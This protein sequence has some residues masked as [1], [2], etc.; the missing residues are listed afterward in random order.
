[1]EKVSEVTL[2][3]NDSSSVRSAG[4]TGSTEPS[5]RSRRNRRER[6]K[7]SN[8]STVDSVSTQIDVVGTA[9]SQLSRRNKSAVLSSSSSTTGVMGS[10]SDGGLV[11]HVKLVSLSPPL[12]SVTGN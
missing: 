7:N 9:D 2:L 3:T 8:K 1:M 12:S 4:V 10:V 5:R 6:H 11:D